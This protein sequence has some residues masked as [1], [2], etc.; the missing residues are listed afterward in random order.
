MRIHKGEVTRVRVVRPR[1]YI[2]LYAFMASQTQLCLTSFFKEPVQTYPGMPVTWSFNNR[3][4]E[5]VDLGRLD[6]SRTTIR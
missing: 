6:S 5:K 3:Q 1:G 4:E 2:D